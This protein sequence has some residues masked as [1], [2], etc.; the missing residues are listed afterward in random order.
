M[1][2]QSAGSLKNE[3]K[4]V[5]EPSKHSGAK[6]KS[7]STARVTCSN[8]CCSKCSNMRIIAIALV[9]IALL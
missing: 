2:S 1:F 5:D 3:Q 8:A 7:F 6:I 9:C 4:S